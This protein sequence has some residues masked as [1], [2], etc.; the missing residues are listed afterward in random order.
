MIASLE[1]NYAASSAR[2]RPAKPASPRRQSVP[3]S[4]AENQLIEQ[5][6]PLVKLVVGQLALALSSQANLDDLYSSGLVGLLDAARKFD[7]QAGS[8][9]ESYARVRI[10][11]AMLDELRRMDWVPRSIHDKAR[12]VQAVVTSLEQAHGQLPQ[13]AQIAQALKMSPAEYAEMMEEIRPA[14]FV[15]L[16]AAP[17]AEWDGEESHHES[18]ADEAQENPVEGAAR[19]ELASLIADRLQALPPMQRQVLALYYFEDLRLREIAATFGVTE[20]RICQIHAQA[21]RAL[22]IFMEK[23]GIIAA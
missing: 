5:H 4:V 6:L 3:G 23:Q 9:F 10:R 11:G 22:R 12:K 20:S 19:R 8:S 14:A 2:P 7:P 18:I 13:E 17:A 21:V 15:C 1:T 16:D